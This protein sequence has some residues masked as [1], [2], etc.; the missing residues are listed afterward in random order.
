MVKSTYSSSRKLIQLTN[1]LSDDSVIDTPIYNFI[2]N[3]ME[4]LKLYDFNNS[5][6][7]EVLLVFNDK[8]ELIFNNYRP[9]FHYSISFNHLGS[10]TCIIWSYENNK[11]NN[12]GPA[13]IW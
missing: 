6:Y 5:Y 3:N 11:H 12:I 10:I 7:Y 8:D 4:S 9:S 1:G 13:E 2:H